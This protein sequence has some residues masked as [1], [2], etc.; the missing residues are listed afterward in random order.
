MR[1]VCVGRDGG[2][3]AMCSVL[4]GRDGGTCAVCGVVGGRDGGKCAVR[5]VFGWDSQLGMDGAPSSLQ[6]VVFILFSP[7]EPSER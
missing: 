4:V 3:I 2:T 5:S 6:C 1:K 7:A